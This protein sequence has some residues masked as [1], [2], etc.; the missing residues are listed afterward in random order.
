M[1][2]CGT[3]FR[4][5]KTR[6]FLFHKHSYYIMCRKS[7]HRRYDDRDRQG[8]RVEK[9]HALPSKTPGFHSCDR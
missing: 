6:C 7:R 8:K 4:H 5:A 1:D 3:K 2:I 9:G